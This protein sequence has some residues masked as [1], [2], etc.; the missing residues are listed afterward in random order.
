[1][2]E[3][4]L[5]IGSGIAG[6]LAA[7]R[8][9]SSGYADDIKIFERNSVVE[10]PPTAAAF[11]CHEFITQRITPHSFVVKWEIE[12]D[13]KSASELYAKKV[14][15]PDFKDKVSIC[16]KEAKGWAI[17]TEYLVNKSKDMILTNMNLTGIDLQ[18]RSVTFNDS[19]H[20]YYDTLISTIP[21]PVFLMISG[22]HVPKFN[23]RTIYVKRDVAASQ[24]MNVMFLTYYPNLNFECY[25]S[26]EWAGNIYFEYMTNRT[27]ESAGAVPVYPGK[28]WA[29]PEAKNIREE[30]KAKGVYFQGRYAR[31]VRKYFVSDVWNSVLEEIYG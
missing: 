3:K 23:S 5:I 22:M 6:L 1:M 12:G 2:S 11:Y 13:K 29:Q 16:E 14:Y 21:M 27:E 7:E 26:T 28:I 24:T 25:R 15:G 19:D 20:F 31:W 10:P 9:K 8:I 18:K 30:F 17:D 4:V